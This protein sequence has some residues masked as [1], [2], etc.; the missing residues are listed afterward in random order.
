MN[1]IESKTKSEREFFVFVS[2][3]SNIPFHIQMN[4]HVESI[5]LCLSILFPVSFLVLHLSKH[6]MIKVDVGF[7]VVRWRR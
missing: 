7:L 4:C 5:N 2:T 3:V 1:L 6:E